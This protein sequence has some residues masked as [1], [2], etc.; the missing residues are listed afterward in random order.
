[1]L[2][3]ATS[4]C[5]GQFPRATRQRG[6]IYFQ[7]LLEDLI[8]SFNTRGWDSTVCSNVAHRKRFVKFSKLFNSLIGDANC[9]RSN[10]IFL[11]FAYYLLEYHVNS[12]DNF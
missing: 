2:E 5:G 7:V 6:A 11:K 10:W 4:G 3:Q 12:S 1:M 9:P 8:S